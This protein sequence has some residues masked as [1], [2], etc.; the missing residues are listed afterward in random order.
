MDD[1]EVFERAFDAI[2]R[3]KNLKPDA[4]GDA[5]ERAV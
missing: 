4:L 5:G 1:W 2:D 3:F